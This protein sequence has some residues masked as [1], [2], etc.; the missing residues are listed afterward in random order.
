[1]NAG[2]YGTHALTVLSNTGSKVLPLFNKIRTC[3]SPAG[4]STPTCRSAGPIA[5]TARPRGTSRFNQQMDM[6]AR[7][8]GQDVI[9]FYK[10]WHIR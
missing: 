1:M 4:R 8:T 5:A 10:R 3:A 2:A 9:E 6:I 7:R